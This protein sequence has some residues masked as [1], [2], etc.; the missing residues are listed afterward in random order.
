[1]VT[2]AAGYFIHRSEIRRS[3]VV[4]S[5][6]RGL[7]RAVVHSLRGK[8][9]YRRTGVAQRTFVTGHAG[10]RSGRDVVGDLARHTKIGTGVT[11]SA[12]TF[13]N[14]GMGICLVRRPEVGGMTN[15]ATRRR[16]YVIGCFHVHIRV[17]IGMAGGARPGRHPGVGERRDQGEPGGLTMAGTASQ[18]AGRN[19]NRRFAGCLDAVMAA[20]AIGVGH[21]V[22]KG[23]R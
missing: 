15:L 20:S 18:G 11:G 8:T 1:M 16:R 5:G 12:G 4:A 6:A 14:P 19:M 10:R 7:H 21:P 3:F 23:H 2:A 9:T 22:G 17:S 13:G